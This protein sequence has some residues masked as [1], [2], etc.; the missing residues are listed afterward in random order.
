VRAL[1]FN[2]ALNIYDA[3]TNGFIKSYLLKGTTI[4]KNE[5]QVFMVAH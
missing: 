2:G 3:E 5:Q 1:V 4:S